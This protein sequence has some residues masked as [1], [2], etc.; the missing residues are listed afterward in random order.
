MFDRTLCVAF[1]LLVLLPLSKCI[2]LPRGL[3]LPDVPEGAKAF[4]DK[5]DLLYKTQSTT[6]PTPPPTLTSLTSLLNSSL[7][8]PI[9]PPSPCHDTLLPLPL[10]PTYSGLLSLPGAD[11]TLFNGKVRVYFKGYGEEIK[12][13]RMILEK[14]EFLQANILEG[15]GKRIKKQFKRTGRKIWRKIRQPTYEEVVVLW[16]PSPKKPSKRSFFRRKPSVKKL[17][18][19]PKTPTPLPSPQIRIF[20]NVPLTSLPS[21][22]PSYTLRYKTSDSFR[23][24][25]ISLLTFF[26]LLLKL[27]SLKY[28]KTL[29]ILTVIWFIRSFLRYNNIRRVY[30]LALTQFL[31][32]TTL[33]TD[34]KSF[35]YLTEVHDEI[36]A[37]YSGIVADW[38]MK[39]YDLEEDIVER[40]LEELRGI[41]VVDRVKGEWE[42][43]GGGI[44][45]AWG[46][47]IKKV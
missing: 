9:P 24:D 44:E 40:G 47:I 30:R 25:I 3:K 31:E 1:T 10:Q 27:T 42:D 20:Q 34:E 23:L 43:V 36:R 5:L 38:L 4:V 29:A 2:L 13:G 35:K 22:L 28:K 7:Y 16:C 19:K 17:L 21:T 18:R 46:D 15:E 41:G 33:F 14:L 39:G 45:K 26:P 8:T 12:D 6:S 37:V 32:R 11:P